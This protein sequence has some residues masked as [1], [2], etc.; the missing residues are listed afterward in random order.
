MKYEQELRKGLVN[1]EENNFSQE[2]LNRI[3]RFPKSE[4]VKI[5]ETLLNL[6][7]LQT[8]VL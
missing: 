4:L 8:G 7:I 6:I 1:Y 5:A 3:S 2:V